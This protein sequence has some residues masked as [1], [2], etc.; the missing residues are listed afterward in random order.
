L[1]ETDGSEKIERAKIEACVR[2][3]F[4]LKPGEIIRDLGLRE[5]IFRK[6]ASYGHFGR[7]D[8][9]WEKTDRVADIK[10]ILGV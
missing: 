5:P 9:P 3:L 2:E 7:N 8:V 6:T 1:I 4:G 10:R